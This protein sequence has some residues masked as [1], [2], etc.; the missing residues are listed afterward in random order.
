MV[1]SGFSDTW[2]GVSYLDLSP[3]KAFEELPEEADGLRTD[4]LR[5]L[6]K[7]DGSRLRFGG[8]GSKYQKQVVS[9]EQEV[10]RAIPMTDVLTTSGTATGGGD[11]KKNISLYLTF[12]NFFLIATGIGKSFTEFDP[13]KIR[14][15]S[16]VIK[17][18]KQ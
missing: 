9:L 5:P 3:Y 12:V 18:F 1:K 15:V 17:S 14:E 8:V 6:E 2:M 16:E 13:K 10:R 11:G 7:L 4:T